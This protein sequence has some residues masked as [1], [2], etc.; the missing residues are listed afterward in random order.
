MWPRYGQRKV[1]NALDASASATKHKMAET[2]QN[3]SGSQGSGM[4]VVGIVA[5]VILVLVGLF[6]LLRWLPSRNAQPSGGVNVT[7]P[8]PGN[9]GGTDNPAPGY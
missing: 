6:V 1:A 5:I 9:N 7:V 8:V 4:G 2:V 3:N